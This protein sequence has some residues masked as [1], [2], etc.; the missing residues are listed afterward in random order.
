MAKIKIKKRKATDIAYI[1]HEG[2]YGDI[3]FGEY[4]DRLYSWARANRARPGFRP[5]AVYLNDPN[6]TPEDELKTRLAISI[7]RTAGGE[8][9]VKV[10]SLPEMEVATVKHKGT[11]EEYGATYARLLEWVDQNGYEVTR[12]PMEVYRGKPKVKRGKMVIKSK[13]M[14]P[15]KKRG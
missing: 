8:G 2:A 13:V 7:G 3:P 6:E 4:Y 11:P 1:E 15:V 9:E 12:P 10:G 5:F 14:F